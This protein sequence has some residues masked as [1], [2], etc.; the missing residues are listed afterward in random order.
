MACLL[1]VD[2]EEVAEVVERRRGLTQVT[3]LFDRRRLGVALSHD[4]AAQLLA[5]FAWHLLPRI[6]VR[7][8]AEADLAILRRRQKN[9]PSVLRHL[10][11]RVVGPSVGRGA[12]RRAQVNGGSVET[13]GPDL[14]PPFQKTRMPR[15]ERAAQLLVV[16]E[17]HVVWDI[18][19]HG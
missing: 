2:L 16:I 14:A 6:G 1:D 3:L 12:Y 10:H 13:V 9:A 18:A 4:D 7:I 17:V 19:I 8:V 11:V 15:R 5:K